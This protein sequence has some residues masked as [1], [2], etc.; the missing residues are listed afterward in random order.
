MGFHTYPIER[1]DALRD[2][3]RYR[4]CSREELL[5]EIPTGDT[6]V[7]DLGSGT[8]FYADEVAPFV[9]TLIAV[10]VQRAMHARYRDHG[11]PSGVHLL[12]AAVASLPFAD[13]TL[14]GAYSIMTH[15]EYATPTAMAEL[16]R[17]LSPGAP[18]VTVDWRADGSGEDGPPVD[19]RF[20]LR[21]ASDHLEQVGFEV[22]RSQKRP[23]TFV[24][25][26]RAP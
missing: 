13:G 18:L 2:L 26:G 1:A 25:V 16:T 8:G 20:S 14:D 12:T 21:E 5:A 22:D 4:F 11:V 19:E 7:A 15:H 24:L 3:S 9:Q 6:V 23:E 10:D 17:V